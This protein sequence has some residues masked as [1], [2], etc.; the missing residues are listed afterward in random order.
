MN[1]EGKAKEQLLNEVAELS[2]RLGEL[3]ALEAERKQTE[4][5]IRAQRDLGLAL[6]A[7]RGLDET[8]RLCLEAAI[9]VAEMDCG[10]IYLVDE[11]SGAV[12]IVSHQGLPPDFIKSTARFDPDS[13][14]TMLVM[15]GEPIYTEHLALGVELDE[16]ER[17]EHLRALAVVPVKHQDRVIA[18]LNVASHIRDEVP[19]R[20]RDAIEAITAQAGGAIARARAEEA[21]G[22][23]EANY[24]NLT[25][26]LD[27]LVYRADPE[28][29]VA[30]YVNHAVERIYGYT[31]EEWLADP[32]LWENTIHPDD[33]ERAFGEFTAA[34]GRMERDVVEY[35]IIRKDG[36]VGWVEDHISWEKDSQ[37]AAVSM[38]GVMYEVTKRRQAEEELR[39]Q[40]DHLGDLVEQRAAELQRANDALEAEITERKRAEEE[41]QSL[42]R[43]PS[44]NRNPVMRVAQDGTIL[45]A[46]EASSPL[47]DMW[48]TQVDGKLPI[49]WQQIAADALET[50][51]V[52]TGEVVCG[53]RI[54][55]LDFAIGKEDTYA[56]IYAQDITERKQAE[57]GIVRRIRELERFNRLAG[58]GARGAHDRAQAAGQRAISRVGKGTAL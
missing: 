22:E 18:C 48:A 1:D 52:Q 45:Y 4:G 29:F 53:D 9:L 26:S 35:R 23:S 41:I 11:T 36:T 51:G 28:T 27:A 16:A 55:L 39:K 47:L 33:Q 32:T 17:R 15:A 10:G 34:Q 49:R 46:N 8:L 44:E 50:D 6:C 37:G 19:D 42:A 12:D 21:L 54:F 43:F 58:G 40:R 20:S 56:N 38:N 14:Q 31:V 5:L 30:T 13:E 7:A 25:E 3:E 57:E 2:Q 24:R